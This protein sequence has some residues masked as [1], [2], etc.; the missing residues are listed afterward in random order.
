MIASDLKYITNLID[1]DE[2]LSEG[3]VFFKT[4]KKLDKY[5]NRLK[6]INTT[7]ELMDRKKEQLIKNLTLISNKFKEAERTKDRKKYNEAIE[8]YR[9][10][11]K[12]ISKREFLEGLPKAA[13]AISILALATIFGFIVKDGV[14]GMV[15]FDNVLVK[16]NQ[17]VG[18]L[19]G[20]SKED[21]AAATKQV[22]EMPETIEARKKVLGA[23]LDKSIEKNST[24]MKLAGGG[25]IASI[26]SKI[27]VHLNKKRYSG[28]E[29]ELRQETLVALNKIKR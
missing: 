4:S 5:I 1:K 22:R 10:V 12:I 13:I 26:L 28:S 14:E 8:G 16:S 2:Y 21:I 15:T 17:A 7:N 24:K 6:S 25:I 29:E 27:I 20:A 18:E 9:K 23:V 19:F 11:L 3:L